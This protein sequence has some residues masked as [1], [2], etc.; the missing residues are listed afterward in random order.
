MAGFTRSV[1]R[2]HQD[3]QYPSIF[4]VDLVAIYDRAFAAESDIFMGGTNNGKTNAFLSEQ[5]TMIHEMAHAIASKEDTVSGNHQSF[6]QEFN[7]FVSDPQHIIPPFTKYAASDAGSEFW[8]DAFAAYNLD[9]EWLQ[10]QY[11]VLYQW[12]GDRF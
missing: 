12:F 6:L 11:P 5:V 8:P 3:A 9:P 4:D 2:S 10:S 7:S 1:S